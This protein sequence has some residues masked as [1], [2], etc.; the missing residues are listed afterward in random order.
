MDPVFLEENVNSVSYG[1]LLILTSVPFFKG[2]GCR[3]NDSS[4][5]GVII[6]LWTF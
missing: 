6:L 4:R 1:T 5:L 3:L 2:M